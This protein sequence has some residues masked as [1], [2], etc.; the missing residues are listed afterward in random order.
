MKTAVVILNPIIADEKY[1]GMFD[2]DPRLEELAGELIASMDET[3][4]NKDIIASIKAAGQSLVFAEM[5]RA[6]KKL[7]DFADQNQIWLGDPNPS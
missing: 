7:Y 1:V 2:G 3:I 5:E 4:F 6:L